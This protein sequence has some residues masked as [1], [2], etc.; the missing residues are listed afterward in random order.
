MRRRDFLRLGAAVSLA[1][2]AGRSPAAGARVVVVGAGYGGATAARYIASARSGIEVTLVEPAEAFV[3]CPLSN[4]VIGGS[5][6]LQDITRGYDGLRRHGVHLVQDRAVAVDT[7]ARTVRLARGSPL[8]YD[9][10]VI[11]PGV[12]FMLE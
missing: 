4:L 2:P 11:S 5:R 3:S 8:P 12:D 6:A 7:G 10:L 9:R 1:A